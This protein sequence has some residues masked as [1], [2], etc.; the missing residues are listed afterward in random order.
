MVDHGADHAANI[1]PSG[2][3]PDTVSEA[4]E[5]LASEGYVDELQLAADGLTLAGSW[6]RHPLATATVDYSFRFEGPSDPADEAIVLGV[7]CTDWGRKGVIVSAYGPY[8][9]P[10]HAVLLAALSKP[11]DAPPNPARI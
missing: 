5:L 3:T 9:D 7:T 10:E 11:P 1:G 2:R 6:A 8:A 4:I